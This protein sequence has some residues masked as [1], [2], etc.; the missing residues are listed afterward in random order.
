MK[1]GLFVGLGLG[2]LACN[3]ALADIHINDYNEASNNRFGYSGSF[4]LKRYDLSGVGQGDTGSWGTLVSPNVVVSAAHA[5][6]AV[7]SRMFFY[8]INDPK[9]E[10]VVRKVTSV[11]SGV[12]NTDLSLAVLNAPV[13]GAKYYDIA[14]EFLTGPPGGVNNMVSAGSFQGVNAYMFGLSPKVQEPGHDQA[15]GRNLISGYWENYGRLTNQDSLFLDY[16]SVPGTS[17]VR[18]ESY[19]QGGD[20]G[21]PLF[22]ERNGKLLLLG[23][24]SFVVTNGTGQVVSSGVSYIGNQ[25]NYIR[26]FSEI[27]NVPEPAIGWLLGAFGGVVLAAWRRRSS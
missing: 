3:L 21:A 11:V 17:S 2:L 5:S 7:G 10:P 8:L 14:D 24:N 22:I 20:S 26:K 12:G 19:L 15:V 18:F 6:P 27:N 4:I 1:A 25:A 23:T 9:A 13:D 16:H